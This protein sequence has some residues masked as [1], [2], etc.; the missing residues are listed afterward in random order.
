M[1]TPV[2]TKVLAD[3]NPLRRDQPAARRDGVHR[4]APSWTWTSARPPVR[5]TTARATAG[6]RAD[7]PPAA[8]Q[9]P[10]ITVRAAGA[11]EPRRSENGLTVL[12][13]G[14]TNTP[15]RRSLSAR[16]ETRSAAREDPVRAQEQ[17]SATVAQPHGAG[18]HHTVAA[19]RSASLPVRSNRSRRASPKLERHSRGEA[20]RRA[21][22]SGSIAGSVTA[23]SPERSAS[24]STL[25][26][27]PTVSGACQARPVGCG[28]RTNAV[29]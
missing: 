5:R 27:Q 9:L 6:R 23:R 15:T 4:R 13:C 26:A 3:P 11:A 24:R 25:R 21:C 18:V 10:A 1:D 22:R 17:V 12:V 28:V 16:C 14:R 2:R 7:H 20:R 8:I 29:P 19:S